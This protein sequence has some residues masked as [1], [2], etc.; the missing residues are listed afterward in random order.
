M[1]FWH[2]RWMSLFLVVCHSIGLLLVSL[3]VYLLNVNLWL[4]KRGGLSLY[5]CMGGNLQLFAIYFGQ[6]RLCI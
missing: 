2:Y 1:R 6:H 4:Y 3:F 5:V